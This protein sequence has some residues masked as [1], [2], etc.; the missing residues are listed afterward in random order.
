LT[1][2]EAQKEAIGK[3]RQDITSRKAMVI[4]VNKLTQSQ[5]DAMLTGYR[6]I[7]YALIFRELTPA[8][9][10]Q[11][12]TRMHARRVAEQAAQTTQAPSR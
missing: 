8:Q 10:K 12:S 7:E 6:R 4:K 1:Y 11:I 9:Q 2:T 3:I 5:K